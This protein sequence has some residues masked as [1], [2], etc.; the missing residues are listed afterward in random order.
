MPVSKTRKKVKKSKAARE[1]KKVADKRKRKREFDEMVEAYH[2]L[3]RAEA[4]YYRLHPEEAP[5]GNEEAEEAG[6]AG[7]EGAVPGS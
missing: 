6:S 2:A 3:E 1:Q 5:D 4:E 7:E